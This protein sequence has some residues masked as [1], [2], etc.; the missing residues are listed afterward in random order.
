MD[1]ILDPFNIVILV[2][3]AVVLYRLYVVLGQRTGSEQ[4]PPRFEPRRRDDDKSAPP[5]AD[6]RPNVIPLPG[7]G[8][9]PSEEAEPAAPMTA[10]DRAL[11]GIV[12]V[13]RS[14]DKEQFLDGAGMAYEMIVTAF[15]EGDRKALKPLLSPEVFD[16]FS[17]AIDDR[18]AAGHVMQT[19]FVGIEKADIVEAEMQGKLARI[20][21]RFVAEMVSVTR[22]KDGAVVAG[23]AAK[24]ETLIDGWT[25]E[26][27]LSSS[28]PNW[29]LVATETME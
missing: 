8:P 9:R 19:T 1:E 24:V 28:D 21:V 14:F 10:L 17:R 6:D 3:A 4:P 5:R 23:D 20:K 29:V 25:F 26:R 7:L 13:D 18:V 11:A 27:A 2:V 16:G 22:D 12:S 15:A